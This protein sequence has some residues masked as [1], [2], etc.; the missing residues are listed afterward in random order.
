[1][2]KALGLLLATL[3]VLAA[4]GDDGAGSD[5]DSLATC[6]EV[7]D[8]AADLLQDTIDIMDSLSTEE[9][10]REPKLCPPPLGVLIVSWS[11]FIINRIC[12]HQTPLIS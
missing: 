1:M 5:P 8:A 6:E 3:L 10:Q 2:R 7:A 12:V 11:K 4:C 9:G